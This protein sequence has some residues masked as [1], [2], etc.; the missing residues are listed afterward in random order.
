M[1]GNATL[2]GRCHRQMRGKRETKVTV[3]AHWV[4]CPVCHRRLLRSNKVRGTARCSNNMG[5]AAGCGYE[6]TLEQYAER[7]DF[8]RLTQE[9]LSDIEMISEAFANDLE[10]VIKNRTT[11]QQYATLGVS[12]KMMLREYPEVLA[13]VLEL[14]ARLRNTQMTAFAL[15]IA[16]NDLRRRPSISSELSANGLL[17]HLGIG[18]PNETTLPEAAE[19]FGWSGEKALKV[20]PAS[21][22]GKHS[23]GKVSK[24]GTK[25][26]AHC[27][28]TL[29][30]NFKER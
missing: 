13:E 24:D 1:A 7:I 4:M 15:F 26:C 22:T 3:R 25:F 23:V 2:L 17:K 16:L 8:E 20:C 28:D 29:P 6:E 19:R 9:R 14:R 12:A 30:K 27:G 11:G 18:I 21:L 10:V 5:G